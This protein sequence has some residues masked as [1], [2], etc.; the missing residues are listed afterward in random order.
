VLQPRGAL[1]AAQTVEGEQLEPDSQRQRQRPECGEQR[2]LRLGIDEVHRDERH[3]GQG[4]RDEQ[5]ETDAADPGAAGRNRNIGDDDSDGEQQQWSVERPRHRLRG[6]RQVADDEVGAEPQRGAQRE[7][8]TRDHDIRPDGWTGGVR[9]GGRQRNDDDPGRELRAGEQQTRSHRPEG[10][11]EQRSA[12]REPEGQDPRPGQRP[13]GAGNPQLT[14]PP[15][16]FEHAE[17]ADEPGCKKL[18]RDR[19]HRDSPVHYPPI[20]PRRGEGE[21]A[22]G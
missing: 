19:P 4:R 16:P 7:E 11:E 17:A 3:A 20:G 6:S 9:L 1:V 12:R 5:E 14:A 2:G 13:R 22:I 18:Q 10:R 15:H 21:S 8:G